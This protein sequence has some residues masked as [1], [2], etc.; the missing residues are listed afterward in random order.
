MAKTFSLSVYFQR[1]LGHGRDLAGLAASQ[2]LSPGLKT[3]DAKTTHRSV[4]ESTLYPRCRGALSAHRQMLCTS[5]VGRA[6]LAYAG[7]L[8][9]MPDRNH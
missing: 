5:M 2:L 8:L 9:G 6:T 3:T 1:R 4:L 7:P